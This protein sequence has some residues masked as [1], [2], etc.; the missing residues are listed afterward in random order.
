[1]KKNLMKFALAGFL[2]FG[3]I[4]AASVA[5]SNKAPITESA[6][7]AQHK[8]NFD[9]YVY[10][11]NYYDGLATGL[12]E[13]LNGTLRE[14]LTDLIHPTSWY[15]YSSAGEDH[16]STQCQYADEDPSNPNNMIYL[17][18]R[19]SVKKNAASTWNREHVWPQSLSG[20][21]WGTG[22]AGTDLL[23]L[24]PTYNDTNSKRGN[25]KYGNVGGSWL[26]YNGMD[27][28]RSS[29]GKFEPL[30]SVK[31]DVA[32][33]IMYVWTAYCEHYANLPEV[34]NVFESYNT[35]LEW[36]TMDKPDLVEGVRND[37]CV[38]SK[39]KNRNPFVD[40]PEYA[41]KIFGDKCTNSVKQACQ[42]AYPDGGVA[43]DPTYFTLSA[44]STTIAV[45]GTTKVSITSDG[46]TSATWTSS[47]ASVATVSN[48]GTVTGVSAGTTTITATSTLV[49]T[50]KNS[51]TITVK[52]LSSITVSGNPTKTT[53]TS[54]QSFDPTGLTVTAH[55]SDGSTEDVTANV[56]WTPSPLTQGTTSVTGT[57]GGKTCT[58]SGITVNAAPVS[59]DIVVNGVA[60]TGW[61]TSSGYQDGNGYIGLPGGSTIKSNSY[62]TVIDNT[63]VINYDIG[64]YGGYDANY[65]KMTVYA[66]DGSGSKVSTTAT[67]SAKGKNTSAGG[68]KGSVSITLNSG[69]TQFYLQFEGATDTSKYLRIYN[70]SYA[71]NESTD[72]VPVTG[73][74]LDQTSLTVNLDA[75]ATLKATITPA[76]ASNRTISW[77]S[78]NSNVADVQNGTIIPYDVG[79]TTITAT[80]EDGGFKASCVVTIVNEVISVTG[81]SIT[82]ESIEM[83]IDEY[84]Y[85]QVNITPENASERRVNYTFSDNSIVEMADNR[86]HALK[87]GT[88]VITGTTLD[89]GFTDTV[90]VT[91]KDLSYG[92][93]DNPL[94]VSQALSLIE[95][96]CPNKNNITKQAIY[97]KGTIKEI[98][99]TAGSGTG[100][101]YKNVYLTDGTKD[102]LVYTL[103]VADELKGQTFGVGDTVVIYGYAKNYSGTLE[104][105]SNGSFYVNIVKL[106]NETDEALAI[107]WAQAF[108]STI[109][110]NGGVTAPSAT[111]WAQ[112]KTTY[113]ELTLGAKAVLETAQYDAVYGAT[114]TVTGIN[115]TN[116][117]VAKAIARYDYIL[118]KYGTTTYENFIGRTVNS[119][120]NP[121]VYALDNNAT[122][123]FAAVLV[124]SFLAAGFV[125]VLKKKKFQF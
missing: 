96:E 21:N 122:V 31:G 88:V 100:T 9:D 86:I 124:T 82:P 121:N 92:T 115:G 34:T 123:V 81:L 87:A 84:R 117:Y 48:S 110:C 72:T 90:T 33:I 74:S 70:L 14:A 125:L 65:S 93:I 25:D 71:A 7:A 95:K 11:G 26:Q 105:A 54:G 45:G 119:F 120:A 62:L 35:L 60:Q 53:Y 76:N 41:W 89:G 91:V 111:A 8:A 6:S 75:F 69:V 3:A 68:D 61:A 18:T 77:D 23:H 37:Y 85:L 99:S 58:V 57:Y 43:T 108:L 16:L 32:R 103:N 113:A 102:V 106:M 5:I 97:C 112:V 29:G 80:T 109:T 73:I 116:D 20:G 47:N 66:V 46:S 94:S 50:V 12:T 27:Y 78:S 30:D 4:S 28:C 63:L 101:Y 24:R 38:T 98:G 2:C 40:H 1:M 19:D 15:T 114:T 17:Y 55:Y 51:I 59:K 107:T 36:H 49:P 42:E 13:G 56:A 64:T 44:T 79:T 10:S 22:Q 104:F 39:Q 83:G 118:S 52:A 67:I